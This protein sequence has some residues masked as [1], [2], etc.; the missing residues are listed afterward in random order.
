MVTVK[1]KY[2]FALNTL[3]PI[4][5]HWFNASSSGGKSK[6]LLQNVTTWQLGT[7][8]AKP[9]GNDQ[10]DIG[11]WT[12]TF[13]LP[14]PDAVLAYFKTQGLT[15]SRL[16]PAHYQDATDSATLTY[17][18]YA[19]VP[20]QLVRLQMHPWAPT[21]PDLARFSHVLVLNDGLP[22]GTVW[23]TQTPTIA[24]EA[25]TK[26]NFA[27]QVHWDKTSNAVTTDRLP[28]TEDVFTQQQVSQYQTEAANTQSELQSQIEQIDAQV[29]GNVQARLAQVPAN[30]PKPEML[31]SSWGGDGSGEPT[32]SAERIGGGTVA[33][34]AGGAA[35]GAAAGDAG[36]G[37]GIGAGV[38]LL[39]GLIYDGVSKS[40]DKKK[41]QRKVAAENEERL[42]QW[43]GQVKA[44]KDQRNH[45]QQEGLAEKDQALTALANR[46]A[47]NHGRI[48]ASTTENPPVPVSDAPPVQPVPVQP[49]SDQ[50]SGPI[51]KS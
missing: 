18:V 15:V 3:V 41:Y 1:V 45:I 20:E 17:Q 28:F 24:A 4:G 32:K 43:H 42:D 2:S 11:W 30:P 46:I 50:P 39:G 38:G 31:S 23:N 7:E 22:A 44:L 47:A 6:D 19:E 5:V 26:L 13:D 8:P 9:L 14:K 37:A 35:F 33:G 51:R 12:S 34:A 36:M 40:N 29:R 10:P 49:S 16:E 27:W 48:D 21:D 25:G